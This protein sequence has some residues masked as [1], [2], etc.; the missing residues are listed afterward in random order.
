MVSLLRIYEGPQRLIKKR[1]KRMADYAR[2]KVIKDR[3]DKLDKKTNEQGEQFLALNDTLKDELPKLF[4]LTG[5]LV[6][7]CLQNYVHLQQKWQI[8]WKKKLLQVLDIEETPRL[9]SI[10]TSF[11]GEFPFGRDEAHLLGII[12]GS[13]ISEAGANLLNTISPSMTLN[14]DDS[15][16]LRRPSTNTND[17]RSRGLS[18]SSDVSPMLPQPDF[19]GRPDD[20]LGLGH[21]SSNGAYMTNGY[22]LNT[23]RRN[24]ATSAVSSRSP[25]TPEIAAS[26][27]LPTSS[28]MPASLHSNRPSTSTGRSTDPPPS[29]LRLSVDNASRSRL[30]A[31]ST[32]NRPPSNSTT[33]TYYTPSRDPA[34]ARPSSPSYRNSNLFSSAMPMEDSP[35]A[36]SPAGED[37]Q[38]AAAQPVREFNVLFLAASVY[39]FNIDRARREAGYPYLTYIAGEVGHLTFLN[40]TSLILFIHVSFGSSS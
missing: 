22:P 16:S 7:A 26:Y 27:R 14:G 10:L 35:R 15:S 13:L 29:H 33:S 25:N 19:G 31:D 40:S 24:R 1:Q 12:N 38:A 6:E 39:E 21:L 17:S 34:P 28:T 23:G 5:R 36:L 30:S 11:A 4:A 8:I 3:G 9:D 18:G 20:T 32:L 37:N 2:Y